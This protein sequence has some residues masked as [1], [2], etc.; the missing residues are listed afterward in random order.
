MPH[1]GRRRPGRV[2]LEAAF[3]ALTVLPACGGDLPTNPGALR[4]GQIG[5]V[6][7]ELEAPLRLGVGTL[8]QV[9]S[10]E[11]SGAWT[12]QESMFYRDLWGDEDVRSNPGHPSLFA[13]GYASL[14]TQ[15][16]DVP[17]QELFIDELSQALDPTCGP[18]RT[19]IRLAIRD[20]VKEEQASW[21]RCADGSL[22]NLTTLDAGPDAAASRVV[23]AALLARNR[24]LGETFVSTYAGSVPFGT[25]DRGEDTPSGLEEPTVFLN[26]NDW[27][28]FWRS[29]GGETEVPAV[30]FTEEMVIVGVVGE[31]EEAGDSVEV[32]RILQ[33]DLGTLTEVYERVPGDF[34]SP[35]A[36]SHVPYHIVVAP[37]TP[38]PIRFADVRVEQVS[39]GS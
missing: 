26:R 6:E 18:T 9:L 27:M 8:R 31:R 39:C 19:R 24:T 34:C 36:R 33:V 17:G 7:V 21:V 11:S 2:R 35:A 22:A 29:H 16:N 3:L 28:T 15:L 30:D 38:L 10:W 32:R 20:D 14:I 13:E 23:L 5:G 1:V 12:L 4:F 25:L 37:R